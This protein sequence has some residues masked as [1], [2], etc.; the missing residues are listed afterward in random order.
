MRNEIE[1]FKVGQKV[2]VANH[3]DNVPTLN[4]FATDCFNKSLVRI[5]C[6]YPMNEFY[7]FEDEVPAESKVSTPED[8]E[9]CMEENCDNKHCLIIGFNENKFPPTKK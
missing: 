3:E 1:K 2:I 5:P 7:N 4:G 9:A 6:S 8:C